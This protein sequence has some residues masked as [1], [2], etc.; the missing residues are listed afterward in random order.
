MASVTITP[1]WFNQ[2]IQNSERRMIDRNIYIIRLVIHLAKKIIF[3]RAHFHM[4]K[5]E[6]IGL[7]GED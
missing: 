5:K 7:G 4:S 1:F 6:R 2:F 3:P